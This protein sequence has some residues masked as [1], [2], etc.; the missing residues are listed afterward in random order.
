MSIVIDEVIADVQS[1]APSASAAT[2]GTAEPAPAQGSPAATLT[3]L[4][5]L[6]QLLQEREVRLACD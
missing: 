5:A 3:A 4:I 2:T 6:Q 1:T